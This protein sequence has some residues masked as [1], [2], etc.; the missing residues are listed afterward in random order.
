MKKLPLFLALLCLLA[1]FA[2]A[3]KS[4]GKNKYHAACENGEL[5]VYDENGNI[6]FMPTT[7]NDVDTDK[8]SVKEFNKTLAKCGCGKKSKSSKSNISCSESFPHKASISKKK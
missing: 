1:S 5:V 3:G 6:S 7:N 4:H 2:F 8:Q